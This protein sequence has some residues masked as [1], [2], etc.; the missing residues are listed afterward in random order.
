MAGSEAHFFVL[1]LWPHL[2]WVVNT[3]D[4][5][6]PWGIGFRNQVRMPFESI[7]PEVIRPG[8]WTQSALQPFAN[9]VIFF[10][11]WGET[12][13]WHFHFGRRKFAGIFTFFLLHDWRE[14]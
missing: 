7:N 3:R 13:T 9:D 4:D 5:L 2:Y 14:I 11:G 8:L 10:D 1:T 12:S 6:L